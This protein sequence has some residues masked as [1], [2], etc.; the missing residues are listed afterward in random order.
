MTESS[1]G[2]RPGERRLGGDDVGRAWDA[3]MHPAIMASLT[4]LLLPLALVMTRRLTESERQT[5]DVAA[6]KIEGV[7]RSAGATIPAAI[8]DDLVDRLAGL[9]S[10]DGS[11]RSVDDRWME[12]NPLL[13]TAYSLLA[14]QYVVN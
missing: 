6:E 10:E 4:R 2:M 11:F 3:D 13:I 1:G 5:R 8:P 12:D 14:R 7:W 9:Q